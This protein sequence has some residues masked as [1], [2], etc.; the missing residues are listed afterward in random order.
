VGFFS[1]AAAA[2]VWAAAGIYARTLI[3]RGAS[4]LEISEARAWIAFLVLGALALWRSR[5]PSRERGPRPAAWITIGFGLS[6]AG[7]NLFY[8]SAIKSLPVAVAIVL[9]YTSPAM[10]VLWLATVERKRPSRRVVW[11]L[12]AA[13][14]GVALLSELPRIMASGGTGLSARGIGF[15]LGSAVAFAAYLLFGERVVPAYGPEG[16][17]ARGFGVASVLWL[18]VQAARGRP[19]TLLDGHLVPGVVLLGFVATVIPF[20]LFVWGLERIGASRSGI[21]STLEPLSA[22]LFAYLWLGQ[23]L[24]GWQLAGAA[25]VMAAIAVVQSEQE[26]AVPAPARSNDVL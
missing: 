20:M 18:V 2:V 6:I 11:A 16:A 1:V 8:Y 25:L 22:A 21:V 19:D 15:A 7:A 17:L 12:A 10:V 23:R 26:P 5:R 13:L 14:A 9:Q 4:P 24:T 3:D